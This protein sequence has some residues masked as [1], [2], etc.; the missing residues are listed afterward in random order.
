MMSYKQ[1]YK[2]QRNKRNQL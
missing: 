2:E 1:R